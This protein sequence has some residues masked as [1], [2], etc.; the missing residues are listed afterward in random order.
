MKISISKIKDG[1]I[2][3]KNIY[4]KH[5]KIYPLIKEDSIITEMDILKLQSRGFKYVDV[6]TKGNIETNS[7]YLL[8]EDLKEAYENLNYIDILKYSKEIV[9][10]ILI[11]P[12]PVLDL[13]SYFEIEQDDF[14]H[15]FNI[16]LMSTFIGNIYNKNQ[17][18][19][20]NMLKLDCLA[21]ASILQF[22][23]K[24]F[25]SNK[26]K[27]KLDKIDLKMNKTIF[28][29][30]NEIIFREFNPKFNNVYSYAMLNEELE[31]PS[32]IK[33]SIIYINEREDGKGLLGVPDKIVDNKE[34]KEIEMAKIMKIANQ[35]DYLLNQ[36]INNNI[37][38]KNV[39]VILNQ[40][41]KTN[42]LSQEIVELFLKYI[43]LYAKGTRVLLSNNELATIEKVNTVYINHP[44][45]KLESTNELID[46]L[47]NRAISISKIVEL[48]IENIR[49]NGLTR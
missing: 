43:P 27:I 33:N 35:Y 15:I 26:I 6:K 42:G 18:Y 13:N 20:E 39:P 19:Q 25:N 11:N 8:F 30:Y 22:I 41:V 44:V 45:V 16:C 21:A 7:A 49:T 4:D 10:K 3:E 29:N 40:A 23:G 34:R 31:L 48:E 12:Y 47:T 32:L 5:N 37:D 24:R 36:V 9:T 17:L 28:P 38:L 14:I 2:A 1:M 46:L